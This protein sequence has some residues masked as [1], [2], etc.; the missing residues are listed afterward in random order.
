[1]AFSIFFTV[2]FTGC[3][4][5]KSDS[6]IPSASGTLT[7]VGSTAMQ[8][9]VEEAATKFQTKNP[10]VQIV[11]QGGGSGTGLT[12]VAQGAADIG[13]SDI[14][15]YE[16]EGIE[17]S[18]LKGTK[19]CVVGIAVVTN[20]NCKIKNLSKKQL[21]DIFTGK[22]I[23]WKE[24]G[25]S[26]QKIVLVNRPKGSGTRISFK[27]FALDGVEEAKGMESDSSGVVRQI[28]SNTPGA[29]GYLALPYINE[30]V[31]MV[32]IDGY[33]PTKENITGGI[34]PVWAYQYM[35][36]KGQPAGLKKAFIDYMLS[37][38]V[39]TTIV[40]NLGYISITAMKVTR[41]N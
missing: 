41:G 25:G 22:I 28:I 17:V 34:Y 6:Q 40:P 36:T 32:S 1:M 21:K 2:T 37:T 15:A 19:V 13:N 31:N 10:R 30:T 20:P 12:Q 7:I 9:L 27:K 26:N 35:Y 24:V 4:N 3:N 29:V 8:P 38:E 16:K 33:T 14:S 39:Q 18:Q 5:Q 11:V 23:N